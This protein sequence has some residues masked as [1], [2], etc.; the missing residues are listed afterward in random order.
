MFPENKA[1]KA[2]Y[3]KQDSHK[4]MRLFKQTLSD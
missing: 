4:N 3:V 1:G 2:Y